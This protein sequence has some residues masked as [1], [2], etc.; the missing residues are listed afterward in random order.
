MNVTC[1]NVNGTEMP[2]RNSQQGWNQIKG[3]YEPTCE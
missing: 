1:D 3:S 2:D